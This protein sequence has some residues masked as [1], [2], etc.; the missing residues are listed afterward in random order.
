MA[1][2]APS[3]LSADFVHLADDIARVAL[4]LATEASD[5]ITGST[6]TFSFFYIIP[7]LSQDRGF[8][9]QLFPKF[10][11]IFILNT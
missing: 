6:L 11:L 4:F 5:Y 1:L 8:F 7:I 10:Q 3:L 9:F 2:I